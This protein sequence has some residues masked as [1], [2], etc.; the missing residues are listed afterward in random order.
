MHRLQPADPWRVQQAQ[1]RAQHPVRHLHLDRADVAGPVVGPLGHERRRGPRTARPR[2][3]RRP[4]PGFWRC[5]TTC[6]F[7]PYLTRV[8]VP[9]TM[10]AST[11][12]AAV[13]SRALT[14]VL[15]PP[16]NSPT[17]ATVTA[18]CCTIVRTPA[19]RSDRSARSRRPA[20]APLASIAATRSR[21]AGGPATGAAPVDSRPAR[22]RGSGRGSGGPV[23]VPASRAARPRAVARARCDGSAA[24]GAVSSASGSP[25]AGRRRPPTPGSGDSWRRRPPH[26]RWGAC[27]C[28]TGSSPSHRPSP[29]GL[30]P[31][32]P[33][34]SG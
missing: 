13:W 31:C 2:S 32:A 28:Y 7:S 8:G 20:R 6:S 9:V 17:T 14:S 33:P 11:G 30:A 22:W 19:R 12:Q 16:L 23:R 25:P 21:T 34:M 24:V 1:P 27:S 29:V 15:L 4:P 3:S 26:P 10:S 5:A 18:R